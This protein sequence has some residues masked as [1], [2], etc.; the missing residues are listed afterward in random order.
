MKEEEIGL[1]YKDEKYGRWR[2]DFIGWYIQL[3]YITGVL[4]GLLAYWFLK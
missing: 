4:L 3:C 1:Y 2:E